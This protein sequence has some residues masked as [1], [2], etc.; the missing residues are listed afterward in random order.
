[1]AQLTKQQVQ[2]AY[3]KAIWVL[4]GGAVQA[5]PSQITPQVIQD[6]DKMIVEIANCSRNIAQIGI[7]IIYKVTIGRVV[8]MATG[9]FD[10][11]VIDTLLDQA[12]GNIQDKIETLFSEWVHRLIGNRRFV[13]CL[14]QARRNWRSKIEIELLG[15]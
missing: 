2:E 9:F 11:I 1:M 12:T 8:D 13:G 3:V 7:D 15:I 5:T 4:F 6:V 14:Y 10:N